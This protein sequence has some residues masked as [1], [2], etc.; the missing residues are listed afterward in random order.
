MLESGQWI[1]RPVIRTPWPLTSNNGHSANVRENR[2]APRKPP[3]PRPLA[4][5]VLAGTTSE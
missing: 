4:S 5:V 2:R 1:R 3:R